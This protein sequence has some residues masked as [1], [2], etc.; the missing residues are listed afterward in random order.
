M[1]GRERSQS[2]F[3]REVPEPSELDKGPEAWG[4]LANAAQKAGIRLVQGNL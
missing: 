3:P 2:F 1:S 4:L